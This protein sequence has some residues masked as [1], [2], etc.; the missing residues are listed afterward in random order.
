MF[1]IISYLFELVNKLFCFVFRTQKFI[2]CV[3]AQIIIAIGYGAVKRFLL[4][5][6]KIVSL[7]VEC[8]HYESIPSFQ[9]TFIVRIKERD[10]SGRVLLWLR[11]KRGMKVMRVMPLGI[12]NLSAHWVQ[13]LLAESWVCN[14]H[15]LKVAWVQ[16]LNGDCCW[17]LVVGCWSRIGLSYS[18]RCN[19]L[20]LLDFSTFVQH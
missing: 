5:F 18:W 10:M 16:G 14:S 2:A 4:I 12:Y 17:L 6:D 7:T 11:D 13:G 3:Q 15:V 8:L 1:K 19:P 20:L 9:S